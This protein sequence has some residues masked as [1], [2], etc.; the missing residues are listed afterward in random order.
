[1]AMKLCKCIRR[2]IL[3]TNSMS[4]P[5][6]DLQIELW[7][8]DGKHTTYFLAEPALIQLVVRYSWGDGLVNVTSLT[9]EGY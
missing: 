2:L 3:N 7:Q 5:S 1:M 9:P 4:P 6:I 8:F